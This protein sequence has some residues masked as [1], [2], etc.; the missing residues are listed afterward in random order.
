MKKVSIYIGSRANFSSAISILKSIK[1][2]KK[3]KLSI[4]IGGA[5]VIPRYGDIRKLLD[6]QGFKKYFVA[7]TLVEGETPI[8]MSKSVGLGI[9]EFSSILDLIKPDYVIAIGDRFDVLPWVISAAMMNICVAHTMGGER[10]GTID[11]SIRHSITKFSNIH[12]PANNDAKNRILKM[13]ENKKD[14]HAVGCPRIDYVLDTLAEIKKGNFISSKSLFK[15]Y[16]GTGPIFSLEKSKFLLVLFH[17]VT[18]EYGSN[19]KHI[20]A[21]LSALNIMK[22]NTILIW[23]N[24]DAGSD[25]ISKG[26]R[27]FREKYNPNWLHLF[28]NLPLKIYVQ[29]MYQCSCLIGNSSSGVREAPTIGIKSINLGSRQFNRSNAMSIINSGLSERKILLSIKKLKNIKVKKNYLFGNGNA[30]KKFKNILLKDSFW[31]KFKTKKF[32]D[33]KYK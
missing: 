19:K 29:L 27:I 26:I 17:P 9:T 18:T 30:D 5:G 8:T 3:L 33:I 13:G 16:R 20:D 11:E 1:N 24:A 23:P 2:S 32:I 25:E 28:I 21:I 12:F 22:M 10:S 7:N 14:V 4:V 15:T 31:K 6:Q